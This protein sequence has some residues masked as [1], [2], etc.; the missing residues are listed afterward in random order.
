MPLIIIPVEMVKIILNPHR[1]YGINKSLKMN[2][3]Q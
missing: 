1:K 3:Y 2:K